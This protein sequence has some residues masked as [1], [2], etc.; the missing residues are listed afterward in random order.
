M[1]VDID[2][3]ALE[4]KFWDAMQAKDPDAASG[5]LAEECIVA[6]AQGVSKIDRQAFARM[7]REGRWTLHEYELKDVQVIS[8]GPD[9]AV[10]GYRV[11]EKVTM[12]GREMTFEAADTSTWCRRDGT[13][14]CLLHT[15]SVLGDPFGQG[16]TNAA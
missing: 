3:I 4:R 8:S 10:I 12:D 6:G 11:R 13:W 16:R 14:R 5:L 1:A 7:T 2:I 9:I 15:E